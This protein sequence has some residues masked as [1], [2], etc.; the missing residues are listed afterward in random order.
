MSSPDRISDL[1]TPVVSS[2]SHQ[3]QLLSSNLDET[4]LSGTILHDEE[5]MPTNLLPK[6]QIKINKANVKHQNHLEIIQNG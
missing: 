2:P 4:F 5:E 6:N 1:S 3:N